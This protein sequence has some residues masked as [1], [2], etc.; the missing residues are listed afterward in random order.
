MALI[1]D[2]ENIELMANGK[3]VSFAVKTFAEV[4]QHRK[5]AI[6]IPH[7][8]N[9]YSILITYNAIGQHI[10]D[11]NPVDLHDYMIFFI[12]P[13]QVHQMNATNDSEGIAILFTEDFLM[14][15]GMLKTILDQLNLFQLNEQSTYLH[16]KEKNEELASFVDQMHQL[17]L[18]QDVFKAE[19]FS[20]YLKLFLLKSYE[21]KMEYLTPFIQ[22]TVPEIVQKFKLLVDQKFL[23][24][25]KVN[26]YAEKLLI[27]PN[28]LNEVIKKH[29]GRTAKEHI[30][31][32]LIS[33]AKRLSYFTQLSSKEIG[34]KLGFNDPSHFA[35]FAKK[36]V[37]KDNA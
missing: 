4:F 3:T 19:K 27:S 2:I 24:W 20:A 15:N 29:T 17:F 5:S 33:E 10:I 36:F 13:E 30:Q 23:E 6:E 28:Y 31:N 18:S 21:L 7:R 25:H 12:H 26:T 8:H 34:F 16:L 11:L 9:F 22:D 14:K 1:R 35:K 32:R 37:L